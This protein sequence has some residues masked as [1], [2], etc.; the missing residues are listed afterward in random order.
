MML[1]KAITSKKELQAIRRLE[2]LANGTL[3]KVI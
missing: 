2:K 3:I 1:F